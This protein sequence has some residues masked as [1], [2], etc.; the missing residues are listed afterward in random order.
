MITIVTNNVY[1]TRD[2]Q[3]S[4]HRNIDICTMLEKLIDIYIDRMTD[5][6]KVK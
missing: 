4:G 2:R 5:R 1:R 6:I 3:L